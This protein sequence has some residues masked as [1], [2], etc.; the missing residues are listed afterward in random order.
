MKTTSGM[1]ARKRQILE[2]ITRAG[3]ARPEDLAQQHNVAAITV[4]RD[5]IWLEKA[6]F[7]KRVH[8]GAIPNDNPLSVI[9]INIR[10]RS[11]M[12]EKRAIAKA[13]VNMIKTGEHIFLDAGSTCHF[14]AE[15]LP[16]DKDLTVITHSLDNA[17]VLSQKRGI[18]TIVLGGELDTRLNAFV[19]PMTETA[20][21]AF[22]ADKAFLGAMGVDPNRGISNNNLAEERI[23]LLMTSNA[24]EVFVLADSSKLGKVT[25]R[26]ILPL[27]RI[28]HIITDKGAP[29]S[30]CTTLRRK[31]IKVIIAT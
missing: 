25:F 8:G 3:F 29:K 2:S 12:D 7:L 24:R 5:L 14:L 28:S 27:S 15:A 21:T 26:S 9:H 18:R 23:K 22:H 4:R 17:H 10:M 13:A 20:L 30:F 6:G 19:S 31:G 11:A 1:D 16:E